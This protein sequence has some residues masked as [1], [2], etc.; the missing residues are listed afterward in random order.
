MIAGP[1][2]LDASKQSKPG[3]SRIQGNE[4]GITST[5]GDKIFTCCTGPIPVSSKLETSVR[6][7]YSPSTPIKTT[8]FVES[9]PFIC[10]MIKLGLIVLRI[11]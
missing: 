10:K 9:S 8:P 2:Q 3:F 5:F 4:Q 7:I 11:K 1:G 6:V